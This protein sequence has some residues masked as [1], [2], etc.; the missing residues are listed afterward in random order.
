MEN[1]IFANTCRDK[2][3]EHTGFSFSIGFSH[4]QILLRFVVRYRHRLLE[5][6]KV[7]RVPRCYDILYHVPRNL[8]SRHL[9]SWLYFK[10]TPCRC[11]ASEE[12]MRSIYR[13]QLLIVY[14]VNWA[15][16]RIRIPVVHTIFPLNAF[17]LPCCDVMLLRTTCLLQPTLNVMMQEMGH[18]HLT[19]TVIFYDVI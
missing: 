11:N 1:T 13:S 7:P 6:K 12:I 19:T 16:T 3:S 5:W 10:C 15:R 2:V 14:F 17:T 18:D 8:P 9:P 4:T